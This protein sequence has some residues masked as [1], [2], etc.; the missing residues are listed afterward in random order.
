MTSLFMMKNQ[1]LRFMDLI[2]GDK[3]RNPEALIINQ[4]KADDI[5]LK[6][7]KLLSDLERKVL[8]LYMDGQSYV[9]ISE[10]LSTQVKSIDYAL[11]RVKRELERHLEIRKI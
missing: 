3:I 1:T 5:D 8:T 9:E 11:Q 4:E 10:E 7:S 2:S 6:I